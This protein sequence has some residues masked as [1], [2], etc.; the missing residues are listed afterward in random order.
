[1]QIIKPYHLSHLEKVAYSKRNC[2][3]KA[4]FSSC[5]IMPLSFIS[6]SC[7]QTSCFPNFFFFLEGSIP[8]KLIDCH[9][10]LFKIYLLNL[11]LNFK[12][13]CSINFVGS[14]FM[15]IF[16]LKGIYLSNITWRDLCVCE[17]KREKER[18]PL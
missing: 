10:D 16:L 12:F 8:V 6:H 3:I 5:W 2:C 7:Y 11:L 14:P 15:L 1:M 18:N 4:F 13:K 17:R 9:L